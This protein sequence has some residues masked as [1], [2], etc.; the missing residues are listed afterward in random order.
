[1]RWAA[2]KGVGN[3]LI[4]LTDRIATV[5]MIGFQL[6]DVVLLLGLVLVTVSLM[7]KLRKRRKQSA[8][9]PT[10]RER[11]EQM[12]QHRGLRGDL[13]TLMV[14]I[15]QMARR[16]GAQLDAKAIRLEKLLDEADEK[17]TRLGGDASA[18]GHARAAVGC[19]GAGG[20]GGNGS[21]GEAGSAV[22]LQD[23]PPPDELTA[24]VYRLAD[25][26]L[27]PAAIAERL[28]EHVGKVELI[29]ALRGV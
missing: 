13:E 12:T 21:R 3:R 6:R 25:Q 23:Q 28:S 9:A 19:E 27:E 17:I 8:A 7:M 1:M 4:G 29:L 5:G 14:E 22:A 15:E 11:L 16:L 2:P 26:G 18:A 24:S 10:S 20:T